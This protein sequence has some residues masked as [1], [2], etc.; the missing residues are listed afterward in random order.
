M[1]APET[2]SS[3][4]PIPPGVRAV[5]RRTVTAIWTLLAA[6]TLSLS[7]TPVAGIH[8]NSHDE[9]TI[10]DDRSTLTDP[11][12]VFV[13]HPASFTGVCPYV[14]AG[15]GLPDGGCMKQ[16]T[17][18][19]SGSDDGTADVEIRV[20]YEENTVTGN[21]CVKGADLDL[22]LY[23]EEGT[24]LK[25]DPGCDS[26]GL[27]IGALNLAAGNYVV[28]VRGNWGAVVEYHA[29]GTLNF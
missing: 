28:E 22:F 16:Y 9:Q 1:S 10:I 27:S 20:E 12:P 5:Q 17:F 19:V 29:V 24:V 25:K 23:D 4:D 11:G 26:G 3:A 14:D 21:P 2:L 7:T 13:G 18:T 15:R 6:I 8:D